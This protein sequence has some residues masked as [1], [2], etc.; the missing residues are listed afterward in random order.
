MA[1]IDPDTAIIGMAAYIMLY[2]IITKSNVLKGWLQVFSCNPIAIENCKI[3]G[4]DFFKTMGP[5]ALNLRPATRCDE[6]GHFSAMLMLLEALQTIA[7]YQKYFL[8]DRRSVA[9]QFV[10]MNCFL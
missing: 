8:R 1:G 5:C 2:I 7:D 4:K 3:P 10:T 9:N 6:M